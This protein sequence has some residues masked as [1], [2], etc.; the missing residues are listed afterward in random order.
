[1]SQLPLNILVLT[2]RVPFP[3]NDGGNIAIYHMIKFLKDKGHN[4][5]LLSFNTTKHHQDKTVLDG[6][7]KMET[8]E[9]NNE[10]KFSGI[11]RG[12]FQKLPFFIKRFESEEFQKK[13]IHLLKNESFDVVQTETIYMGLY[14]EIVKQNSNTKLVLRAHNIE[15]Q[16]WKRLAKNVVSPF[17]KIY[18][19]Y[20]AKRIEKFEMEIATFYDR[21]IPITQNDA[22]FYKSFID[23]NKIKSISAGID[24]E[25][26]TQ[27]HSQKT[28]ANSICFLGSL[29]WQ[30][31][32][33][34][35]KWFVKN[36]I[37]KLF[38]INK[39]VEFHIAGK[40]PPADLMHF[41]EKRI[42]MHG[43]VEDAMEFLSKYEILVV[44][45]LSGSG[46]RLKVIEAMALKK[47]IVS[48]TIGSEG[49]NIS[50]N[51]LALV[52][53]PHKMAYK[54]NALLQDENERY[55]LKTNAY[56]YVKQHYDWNNLV[57]QFEEVYK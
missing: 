50:S 1:M 21:V 43:M 6:F 16:I 5:Q 30:P 12:F 18:F 34:G 29:E 17:K 10:M 14:A 11:L 42:I 32:I 23:E 37:P 40:N 9:L 19:S 7:V 4:I 49:I 8:V 20:L 54:I 35:L 36:V 27:Y 53:E 47:C 45:L 31:N 52:D 22:E 24:F 48:T 56:E 25:K 28:V 39:S 44:P 15:S 2:N 13:L 55:R 46:M 33:Q 57:A 51:E 26:Y 38:E 3:L 41:T